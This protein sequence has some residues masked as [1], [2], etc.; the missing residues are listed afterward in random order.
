MAMSPPSPSPNEF[1]NINDFYESCMFLAPFLARQKRPCSRGGG[2]EGKRSSKAKYGSA[3]EGK[4]AMDLKAK[5]CLGGKHGHW[6]ES[7][8]MGRGRMR[9]GCKKYRDPKYGTKLNLIS[10]GFRIIALLGL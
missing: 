9:Q 2:P 7:D 6:E 10:L 5:G 4:K 8:L 3:D 1:Y